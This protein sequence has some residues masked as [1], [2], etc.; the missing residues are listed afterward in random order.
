MTDEDNHRTSPLEQCAPGS[1]ES[2]PV[3]TSSRA[4]YLPCISCDYHTL[5]DDTSPMLECNCN[6][7]SVNEEVPNQ[8]ILLTRLTSLIA[9]SALHD[10]KIL[11]E[12]SGQSEFV[13]M[14]TPVSLAVFSPLQNCSPGS[15]TCRV[16]LGCENFFDLSQP[17]VLSHRLKPVNLQQTP[18]AS[19]MLDVELHLSFDNHAFH[20]VNTEI[21]LLWKRTDIE[22]L[23]AVIADLRA[24]RDTAK[25][26]AASSSWWNPEPRDEKEGHFV[27]GHLHA[28]HRQVVISVRMVN[29]RTIRVRLIDPRICATPHPRGHLIPSVIR[30]APIS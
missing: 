30:S 15:N 27:S 9:R 1:P 6:L 28:I 3:P 24:R 5:S 7:G 18:A 12:D 11:A 21:S 13:A 10:A 25:Q 14:H 29:S 26:H 23:L 2:L 22:E 8:S 16:V 4:H 19:Q 20:V 17:N